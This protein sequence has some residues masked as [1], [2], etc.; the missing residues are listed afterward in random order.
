VD[1]VASF[2]ANGV[3]G[4]GPFVQDC[5]SGCAEEAVP[6]TYYACTAS[7]TCDATA[8]ATTAQVQNPV[9]SFTTDNNGVIVQLP[10]VSAS[11]EVTV[12]GSLIFG[13]DTESNNASNASGTET[14]LTVDDEDYLSIAYNGHTFSQ[15]FNDSSIPVC[16][17]SGLSAFYCP[18]STLSLSA[19]LTGSNGVTAS[20]Q[21]DVANT[22]TL[23]SG[24]AQ[25]AAFPDLGGTFPGST[26]SFDMGLPFYYGRRVA[27]VIQGYTSTL[28][29]GPYFAF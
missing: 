28:G 14:M 13:V 21:F 20:V 7:G 4:I 22:A 25:L 1:T 10:S 3:L 19:T 9:P 17:Q 5:G 18:S 29:A 24:S 27:T 15:S 11:G 23:F 2:G 12:S 6:T 16:T 8:V 26:T